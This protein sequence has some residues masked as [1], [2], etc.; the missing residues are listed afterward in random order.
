MTKLKKSL[1]SLTYAGLGLVLTACGNQTYVKKSDQSPKEYRS[2]MMYCKGEALGS[3]NNQN[4]TSSLQIRSQTHTPL[5]YD[6]CMR[7]MGYK[8]TN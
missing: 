3:W 6:D 1:A 7:Q 8:Q 4:N 5:S 2:D